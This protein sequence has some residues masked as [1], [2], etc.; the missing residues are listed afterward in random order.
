M[1]INGGAIGPGITFV[2]GIPMSVNEQRAVEVRPFFDR[3]LTVVLNLAAPEEGLPLFIDCLQF[4]P[5]VE[6][7]DG[8]AGKEVSDFA[9]ANNHIHAHIVS[10][11]HGSIHAT[12]RRRDG[13]R[14]SGRSD[15]QS[16][17]CLFAHRKGGG[18]LGATHLSQNGCRRRAFRRR[19]SK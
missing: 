10:A 15:W 6:G 12:E 8:T 4:E 14:L 13:T 9:G 5:D 7:V 16:G 19:N 2:D 1:S 17:L 18:K 11:A 3:T